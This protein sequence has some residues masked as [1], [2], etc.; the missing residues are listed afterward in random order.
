[1]RF[2]KWV[3]RRS[4]KPVALLPP[5]TQEEAEPASIEP[6][7][8]HEELTEPEPQPKVPAKLDTAIDLRGYAV[9]LPADYFT[10]GAYAPANSGMRMLLAPDLSFRLARVPSPPVAPRQVEAR[11]VASP[12]LPAP[13]AV[14]LNP[15]DLTACLIER[16]GSPNL[17]PAVVAEC[18]T[19]PEWI[20]WA[21]QL[22]DQI[23][24]NW[25]KGNEPF[26][27]HELYRRAFNSATDPAVA[28]LLCFETTRAFARGGQT[29]RWEVVDRSRG[30]YTDGV[31]SFT[32]EVKH[33]AGVL[34]PSPLQP[35]SIFY[36]LFAA[37]ELGM[38]D[39]GDWYRFFAGATVAC[40]AAR[41]R[42][43]PREAPGAIVTFARS[44]ADEADPAHF[45]WAW[46]NAIALFET[47]ICARSERRAKEVS[48]AY[49]RGAAFGL[50][51][52]GSLALD[53]WK[54]NTQSLMPIP[55]G[56][57]LKADT[58]ASLLE[59]G[60]SHIRISGNNASFQVLCTVE[61]G[62]GCRFS[63]ARWTDPVLQPFAATIVDQLGWKYIEHAVRRQVVLRCTVPH[64][65]RSA[66]VCEYDRGDGFERIPGA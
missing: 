19:R 41:K 5:I 13:E 45:G 18:L 63:S 35:P 65:D 15:D 53:S 2:W 66:A 10:P 28:L 12:A 59:T 11:N 9:T 30:Q 39:P 6:A 61:E 1:M 29:I 49:R 38:A 58:I 25:L 31:H 42:I 22:R 23:V 36:L 7:D 48:E 24:Q 37:T 27:T 3:F 16:E 54:W 50:E 32:A 44:I 52:A 33:R 47:A 60:S 17:T 8:V 56:P 62:I 55:P 64:A 34:G 26:D 46:A 51:E 57:R 20:A 4:K 43:V 40:F 14:T 21:I